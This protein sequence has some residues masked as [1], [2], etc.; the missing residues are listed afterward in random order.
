MASAECELHRPMETS[1]SFERQC[2]NPGEIEKEH[3]GISIGSI[4]YTDYKQ[5]FPN[6]NESKVVRRIDLK[7]VPVLSIM[8]LLAFLDRV[9]ISNAAVFGMKRDLHL[10]GTEYNTALVIFFV[11]FI[12]F[13]IPSNMLLKH[14][15]PHVWLPICIFLFGAV[16]ICQG[17]T[18]NFSGLVATRF[19]LGMVESGVS[20]ACFYIIAM[21]YRREEAQKRFSFFW[22]SSTLAG[23]FG[24]LLASAIGK[25]DGLRGLQGWRWIFILEGIATCVISVTLYFTISD[26]PED[27]T[28][29]TSEEKEFV[30]AR[31]FE[32]VGDSRKDHPLNIRSILTVFK[33]FKIILGGLLYFGLLVPA[34]GYAY[35][36]TSVIQDLGH[37][38]IQTQLLS[39]PP[40]ACSYV[41][42]MLV[43]A[44]SDYCHHRFLFALAP[45]LVALA[46]YIILLIVHDDTNLQY[47][48]LFI[49][50]IGTY[51][52][53]PIVIC[54]FNTN[55]GGHHRRAVGSAWQ[56]GFGNIGG[57]IAVYSFLAQDAP[58]Y[59]PGYSICIAFL[60]LAMIV[61]CAY[62]MSIAYENRRRD[63]V[64]ADPE[65]IRALGEE[66]TVG[67][68]HLDF[69][70]LL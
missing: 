21:W 6:I 70:Y 41:V 57:I 49:C 65:T 35:F 20:P 43:A 67:D 1:R 46:G 34:Y 23:A 31:L 59:I 69:R 22:S 62:L 24:G 36:A 18:Q 11:P 55:L 64:S 7:V 26:F 17:L 37:S 66:D 10:K 9:N 38:S 40:W 3:D 4:V 16:S 42:T 33:D 5:R 13:E 51:S 30:K 63:L 61:D 60:C 50:A 47:G 15:K 25:M 2:D 39:V 44:A 19:F 53:M 56:V 28:W 48:A 68:L 8:Y 12:I 29:L 14:F 32:D 58:K 54:W 27:A 52:A 45:T